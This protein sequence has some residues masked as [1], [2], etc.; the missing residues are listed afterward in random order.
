MYKGTDTEAS[1][2]LKN[3]CAYPCNLDVTDSKSIAEFHNY[4]KSLMKNNPNYSEL[5]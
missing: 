2:A 5:F 4:I 3:L 1:R